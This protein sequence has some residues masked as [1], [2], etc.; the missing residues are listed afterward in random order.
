MLDEL[1]DGPDI[2]GRVNCSESIVTGRSMGGGATLGLT[3]RYPGLFAAGLAR[4]PLVD[5]RDTRPRATA[6]LVRVWGA[7]AD[8]LAASCLLGPA[9]L[10]RPHHAP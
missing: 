2:G 1:V 8:D 3:L 7:P 4:A 5:Y 10:I 6:A 9:R